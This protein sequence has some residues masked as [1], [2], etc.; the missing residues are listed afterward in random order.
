MTP[1]LSVQDVGHRYGA[2][3]AL[4][5]VSFDV[6]TGQIFGL[7]GPNGG[8]KTTLFRLIATLLPLESG[9]IAIAGADVAREPQV[10]RRKLGVT[11]QS[12]SLDGKL[13]IREN[14]MHQGHLYGLSGS[15]LRDRIDAVLRQ[16]GLQDRRTEIVDRLS[17]GMKRRTEL[18]KS[19]LHQP[20]VLLLDE[21]STGLDPG[22]RRDL[23]DTLR[24]LRTE[25]GT[26]VLVTTHL[27]E[28]AEHCDSLGILDRGRLVAHGSPTEL[29]NSLGG[30]C[31][32]IR[33]PEAQKLAALIERTF[34]ATP[35]VNGEELRIEHARAGEMMCAL[36]AEHRGE[37]AAASLSQPSLEDVFLARTG[38]RF[39]DATEPA[40][41]KSRGPRHG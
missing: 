22:A 34:Q 12:A 13:T 24:S 20:E 5:D 2:R 28:E 38:H 11:F 37:L 21:P 35:R 9:T 26:T 10:V 19:L 33:S 7:L 17:G 3:Q 39:W 14:L 6:P 15:N 25:S 32:T 30:D 31:L 29:R 36:V 18:A 40:D 16:V 27:M 41:E 1:A 8:G 4:D 23:W